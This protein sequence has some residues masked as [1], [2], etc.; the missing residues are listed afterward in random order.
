MFSDV[1]WVLLASRLTFT[2]SLKI[3]KR[4]NMLIMKRPILIRLFFPSK[5]FLKPFLNTKLTLT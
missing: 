3:E 2:D 1:I 5:V 4:S